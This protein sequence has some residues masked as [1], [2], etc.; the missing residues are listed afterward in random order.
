MSQEN[1]TPATTPEAQK[2][3]TPATEAPDKVNLTPEQVVNDNKKPNE[4]NN[5]DGKKKDDFNRKFGALTAKEREIRKQ[6]EEIK[7]ALAEKQKLEEL[8]TS[9][10][11]DPRPYLKELGWTEQDLLEYFITGNSKVDPKVLE[12]EEKLS[13]LEQEEKNKQER[14]KQEQSKKEQEYNQNVKKAYYDII[15]KT[16]LTGN[17]KFE[18]CSYNMDRVKDLALQMQEEDYNETKQVLPEDKILEVIEL[19]LEKEEKELLEKRKSSKKLATYFSKPEPSKDSGVSTTV[20]KETDS[21]NSPITTLS[22][23]IDNSGTSVAKKPMTTEE[24]IKLATSMI[25]WNK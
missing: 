2:P 10:K 12:L 22:S 15:E 21:K 11:K 23:E 6:K 1:Q 13:R 4:N 24:R 5:L 25:K 3:T 18:L 9:A 14:E 8:K 20:K 17:E 19:Q 7:A 16:V